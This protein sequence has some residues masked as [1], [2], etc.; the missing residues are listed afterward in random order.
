VHDDLRREMPLDR[1]A[2]R[3]RRENPRLA[4]RAVELGRHDEFRFR[5][6]LRLAEA[7]AAAVRQQV[8]SAAPRAR[9]MR[10]G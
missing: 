8:A 4:L 5:E 1:R 6:R 10:S 7:G 9:P 3:E 2:D